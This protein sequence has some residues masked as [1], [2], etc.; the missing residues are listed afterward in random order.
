MLNFKIWI[1][2]FVWLIVITGLSVMPG[3]QLPDIHFV[4]PDKLAH[5]FVYAIFS[6]LLIRGLRHHKGRKP[7]IKESL[8]YVLFAVLW[9]MFMEWVQYTFFPGRYCEFEDMVANAVGAFMPLAFYR[10]RD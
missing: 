3:V 1:P 7:H 2:A 10:V 9:G 4:A 5:A 8:P 6:M